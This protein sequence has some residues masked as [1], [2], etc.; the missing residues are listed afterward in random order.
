MTTSRK[1]SWNRCRI[2]S[3]SA[4]GGLL[5]LGKGQKEFAGGKGP[6]RAERAEARESLGRDEGLVP[7]GLPVLSSP[8]ESATS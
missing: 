8:M 2:V 4:S 5:A 1:L 6:L 3:F 7:L